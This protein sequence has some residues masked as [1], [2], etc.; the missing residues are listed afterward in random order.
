MIEDFAE[1]TIDNSIQ[2]NVGDSKNAHE[3]YEEML[4]KIENKKVYTLKKDFLFFKS[5][6]MV[7]ARTTNNI[8]EIKKAEK[9]NTGG[10]KWNSITDDRLTRD[11][12]IS[13]GI[14]KERAANTVENEGVKIE[15]V[16]KPKNKLDNKYEILLDSEFDNEALSKRYEII[17]DILSKE[18]DKVGIN[19]E[20]DIASYLIEQD[21]SNKAVSIRL[22]LRKDKESV[23]F[24][25]VNIENGEVSRNEA[26]EASF[27]KTKKVN[28][29]VDKFNN[30]TAKDIKKIEKEGADQ[31]E[32]TDF[33]NG[34]KENMED[35]TGVVQEFKDSISDNA[36]SK[37]E[38]E[39]ENFDFSGQKDKRELLKLATELYY[40][41]TRKN[42][43]NE[44]IADLMLFLKY[45][46]EIY[47]TDATKDIAKC[48]DEGARKKINELL[49]ICE[50]LLLET[51]S[52]KEASDKELILSDLKDKIKALGENDL[53]SFIRHIDDN[54]DEHK[55][56]ER[57]QS[58]SFIFILKSDIDFEK[59]KKLTIKEIK[60]IIND[61]ANERELEQKKDNEDKEKWQKLE[62]YYTTTSETLEKAALNIPE[63]ERTE[64]I[65]SLIELTSVLDTSIFEMF[66]IEENQKNKALAMNIQSR[67]FKALKEKLENDFKK[68]DDKYEKIPENDFDNIS[69]LFEKDDIESKCKAVDSILSVGS[70]RN[71]A[72]KIS[73]A[74]A[75]IKY[76]IQTDDSIDLTITKRND[77]VVLVKLTLDRNKK[78]VKMDISKEAE[79]KEIEK[80]VMLANEKIDKLTPADAEKELK[81]TQTYLEYIRTYKAQ[82]S[83]F[84]A[85]FGD[86]GL[87]QQKLEERVK[88]SGESGEYSKIAS[89]IDKIENRE[90][91]TKHFPIIYQSLIDIGTKR[92]G[93]FPVILNIFTDGTDRKG[94]SSMLE[95]AK[96][97]PDHEKEFINILLKLNDKINKLEETAMREAIS[98]EL[99]TMSDEMIMMEIDQVHL[100]REIDRIIKY[101]NDAENIPE[102]T[103]VAL[104]EY[105][106]KLQT[107]K[108]ELQK[109][110][111]S[112]SYKKIKKGIEK[113]NKNIIEIE[114]PR[115]ESE[116]AALKNAENVKGLEEA[117]SKIETKKFDGS[118]DPSMKSVKETLESI[119]S[120]VADLKNGV[121]KENINEK[122]FK[123]LILANTSYGNAKLYITALFEGIENVMNKQEVQFK[124][125]DKVFVKEEDGNV[126]DGWI[127]DGVEGK[128]I[129][130]RNEASGEEIMTTFGELSS[131]NNKEFTDK[132]RQAE[133]DKKDLDEKIKMMEYKAEV[134]GE[135]ISK[136]PEYQELLKHK[137]E[138]EGK[139]PDKTEKKEEPQTYGELVKAMNDLLEKRK[140]SFAK[141]EQDE[142]INQ[143]VEKAERGERLNDE[144]AKL[145]KTRFI[146]KD[147]VTISEIGKTMIET[148]YLHSKPLESLTPEERSRVLL[149]RV[150]ASEQ[151]LNMHKQLNESINAANAKIDQLSPK[152]KSAV[153]TICSGFN[154][155]VLS[156]MEKIPGI[157]R[158]VRESAPKAPVSPEIGNKT[159]IGATVKFKNK[160]AINEGWKIVNVEGDNVTVEKDAKEEKTMKEKD[161]MKWNGI[162]EKGKI[163]KGD[164]VKIVRKNKQIDTD[165]TVTDVVGDKLKIVKENEKEQKVI[166]KSDIIDAQESAENKDGVKK[167]AT[168][169]N[170]LKDTM[171]KT[172]NLKSEADFGNLLSTLKSKFKEYAADASF[173]SGMNETMQNNF[174]NLFGA[175]IEFFLRFM[176]VKHEKGLRTDKK[177]DDAK[178]VSAAE[179]F[180]GYA[181][182][183][184]QEFKDFKK[185]YIQIIDA[186]IKM[187]ESVPYPDEKGK[188]KEKLEK[189]GLSDA[190]DTV[191][192]K[193]SEWIK[194]EWRAHP[195]LKIE[196]S[197]EAVVIDE[198]VIRNYNE[199]VVAKAKSSKNEIP[200]YFVKDKEKNRFVDLL[201]GEGFS[202]GRV[203]WDLFP[204]KYKDGVEWRNAHEQRKNTD[205]YNEE[206]YIVAFGHT[207]PTGY[208]P[209]FSHI[210]GSG[211]FG[212][213]Y[214]ATMFYKNYKWGDHHGCNFHFV[215]APDL[216]SLGA[217][218]AKENGVIVF[219]PIEVL[220][221]EKPPKGKE[222]D[223]KEKEIRVKMLE[224]IFDP[225]EIM[226]VTD[227][228]GLKNLIRENG[229][230]LRNILDQKD[231]G[232]SKKDFWAFAPQYSDTVI[233]TVGSLA[234][235]LNKDKLEDEQ[236]KQLKKELD[237]KYQHKEIDKIGSVKIKEYIETLY[238]KADE[239]LELGLD[240]EKKKAKK[241]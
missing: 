41:I 57:Y 119:L 153:T 210:K 235:Y 231:I 10:N 69:L 241:K 200:F 150:R 3:S 149:D 117:I 35:V 107:R 89:E 90:D 32:T 88:N 208:G 239:I 34:T 163:K 30:D 85:E 21:K 4:R 123:N 58:D 168:A 62:D 84:S 99:N 19:W 48:S 177:Q 77:E 115:V 9:G 234:Y 220:G 66:G 16:I 100:Q 207:H 206:K 186:M 106:D 226:S 14:E 28:E 201:V 47:L 189:Y 25:D 26:K 68:N 140:K 215:G 112:K 73:R 11:F 221:K 18:L 136:N 79:A 192:Q 233:K 126:K 111:E 27:L 198:E 103:G 230:G 209:I 94:R 51:K 137:E 148:S 174:I 182:S 109:I 188:E 39:F 80:P 13:A 36:E 2:D 158:L 97:N 113:L 52:T 197:N 229:K 217:I 44:A 74:D 224:D 173:F 40:S 139:K 180:K 143:I 227:K 24:F 165:W 6:E 33:K 104:N 121:I 31:K 102:E 92:L 131:V 81:K 205:N 23:Y 93:R 223:E 160:K 184:P 240:S 145:Y 83:T 214:N 228:E 142:R 154:D 132:I 116:T 45:E 54:L 212:A 17:K 166:K 124:V 183:L 78:S 53:R 67:I 147:E 1:K 146:A 125:G 179:R 91:Y 61:V 87:Y 219:H 95:A 42:I 29:Q 157:R 175:D 151:L 110:T 120:E 194:K 155:A 75:K 167:L 138:L 118:K 172:D 202:T 164:K 169:M 213:D 7:T 5:G 76:T 50:T 128:N 8:L 187:N 135:D 15:S 185:G 134:D 101:V 46:E 37:T 161:L 82:E 60:E 12:L 170:E 96:N 105:I 237:Y 222:G 218:E 59:I 196:I 38:N 70:A 43:N 152:R 204:A 232:E 72:L 203:S 199:L 178:F 49:Q 130:V 193:N 238:K 129:K 56:E 63:N 159:K 211:E 65:K 122:D 236:M 108:S 98:K 171:L 71:D 225:A 133:K 181:N 64:L 141:I 176:K 55:I 216:N 195:N 144:E 127:V 22:N 86:Y 114:N 191:A 156:T 162:S 20:D 190:Y